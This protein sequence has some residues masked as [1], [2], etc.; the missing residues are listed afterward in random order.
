MD[1]LTA[2]LRQFAIGV[3]K[4]DRRMVNVELIAENLV[5]SLQNA[6]ALRGRH[7]ADQSVATQ[8]VRARSEAPDMNVV[9]VEHSRHVTHRAGY[10][11]QVDPPWKPFEQNVER[12]ADNIDRAPYNQSSDENRENRI[13]CQPTRIADRDRAHNDC[14]GTQRI[15]EHVN[16]SGSYIQVGTVPSQAGNDPDI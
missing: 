10:C 11:L 1:N 12:L 2:G 6:I 14:N 8:G 13:D 9:H 5:D 4:L 16:G 3:L 15:A 7:I